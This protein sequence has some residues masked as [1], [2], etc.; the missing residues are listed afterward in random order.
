MLTSRHDRRA[1][2]NVTRDSYFHQPT[3]SLPAVELIRSTG[4]RRSASARVVEGRVIITVPAGMAQPAEAALVHD[5]V[6]K[7]LRR[8]AV[9]V[10]GGD[11]ALA[12]RARQVGRRWFDGLAPD[13][14]RFSHRMEQRWGSCTPGTRT[15]RIAAQVAGFPAHVLDGVLA[16]ELAHLRVSGHGPDFWQLARRFPDLDR[17]DAYLDG[18]RRGFALALLPAPVIGHTG[19]QA[20]GASSE[21]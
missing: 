18:V 21:S 17:A 7:V 3:T 20:G 15:I 12:R 10:F 11:E 1:A 2:D 19:L 5:L 16:H 8:D 14:I 13:V 4:R 9:D 6:S